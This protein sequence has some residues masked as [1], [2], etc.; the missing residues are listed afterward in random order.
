MNLECIWNTDG[1]FRFAKWKC[2]SL[3]NQIKTSLVESFQGCVMYRLSRKCCLSERV[4]FILNR[5]TSTTRGAVR[6]QARFMCG[7]L[8]WS[9]VMKREHTMQ[10]YQFRAQPECLLWMIPGAHTVIL[11][12][13]T[14]LSPAGPISAGLSCWTSSYWAKDWKWERKR[15][16]ERGWRKRGKGARARRTAMGKARQRGPRMNAA[17]MTE[18]ARRVRDRSCGANKKR[19]ER[20]RDGFDWIN[21]KAQC[22]QRQQSQSERVPWAVKDVLEVEERT[23]QPCCLLFQVSSFPVAPD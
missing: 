5:R 23:A 13:E 22:W 10:D 14:R 15:L 9:F 21:E 3:A 6:A 4:Y 2:E 19:R 1:L 12:S 11:L 17:R 7:E 18:E 16:A 8:L 20:W